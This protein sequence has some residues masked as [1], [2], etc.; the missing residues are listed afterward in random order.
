MVTII[1]L[2]IL[3]VEKDSWNVREVGK[4]QVGKSDM[5]LERMKLES[6]G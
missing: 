6:P 1:F 5:K 3:V 4:C 2:E